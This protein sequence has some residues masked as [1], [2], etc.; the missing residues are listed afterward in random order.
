MLLSRR[1]LLASIAATAPLVWGRE[2]P[3]DAV[4]IGGG[5]GGCAAALAL[6]RNG[7]RVVLTEETD[8]IGGQL[9]Q[10]LVPPDENPW[11]ELGGGTR[12]YREFRSGVREYYRQ[13]YPLNAA[14]RRDAVLNP[15]NCT[16]S[17]LCHEPAVGVAVLEAM[18]APYVSRGL[19][20]VLLRHKAVAAGVDKALVRSIRVRDLENGHEVE[21]SG[22]YFLDAT[23]LGDLLP[24]T[25]T[26]YVTGAEAQRETGELH[27]GD[28]A[29]PDNMQGICWTFA[30]D[31]VEGED[32]TIE[33]PAEYRF[34]RDYVPELKPA[35]TGKLLS[36]TTPVPSTLKPIERAFDPR[37][38]DT[39]IAGNLWT[40]RRL[41]SRKNFEADAYRGDISV[42]NWPQMDYWLGNIIEVEQAVA[43][44][45]L[46]RCRQ[47]SLSLL[48]WMQTE[49]PRADG[50]AGWKGLRLRPDIAGTSDGLAKYPYIR[51]ARRIKA[52]FTVREEHVGTEQRMKM[53]GLREGEVTAASFPDA[54]GIGSYR[55]DLHPSTGGDN[56]ID[57]S[58][59]PFE[60]PLGALIPEAMENLL[61]ACKNLGTTHITNGCYRLH[62]VEWNIGE[63]AGML[64]AFSILKRETPRGIR[65]RKE[66]LT[67][68]QKGLQQQ[69]VLIRWSD[70]AH[71]VR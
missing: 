7:L 5:V 22:R 6:A 48:Y 68:F 4:V 39:R 12:S 65:N 43:E 40:Y 71:T 53:T 23:E 69:G 18:L 54:V 16:V 14:A 30:M 10:Q 49:A 67:E 8:W 26:A 3:A 2:E 20:R 1:S 59:L 37:E 61:P 45:N 11:I 29:R 34:W 15:G 46:Q 36:W 52:E 56:Y 35:W 63:S 25:K 57:V 33:Q 19:L 9:T 55:I 24:M 31:Y 44:K 64:A 17:A 60:I 28:S 51:E 50:G 38:E 41:T 47:L 13:N 70:A 32:H 62:P 66:L 42:V 21:L 58:S 27:A